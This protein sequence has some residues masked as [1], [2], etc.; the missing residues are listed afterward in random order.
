MRWTID[1]P[2]VM[3]IFV[4]LGCIVYQFSADVIQHASS[5]GKAV[6]VQSAVSCMH[7]HVTAAALLCAR[8][9]ALPALLV[10]VVIVMH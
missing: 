8:V 7:A 1:Q 3:I 2:E 5:D 6:L 4:R 9:C 10:A